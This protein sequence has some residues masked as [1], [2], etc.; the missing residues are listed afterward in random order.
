MEEHYDEQIEAMEEYYEQV[1]EQYEAQIDAL[2]AELDAFKEGY[3][4]AEDMDNAR[5][6]AEVMAANEEAETWRGRLEN[7]AAAVTEYNRLLAMLGE[8]GVSASADFNPSSLSHEDIVQVSQIDHKIKTRATGDSDFSG[9]EIALV[10]ESPNAELVLGSKLNRSVNSGE[11]VHLS[12]GSGV[13]NAESTSTLA[14]ILNGLAKPNSSGIGRS[15]QQNFS[16]GNIT[17]PNVTDAD[18][19]VKTLSTQFNNYAIQYGNRR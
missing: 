14:G 2:Q 4:K 18:S 1:Q 6:A 11:L 16:F 12:R 17:L 15:T 10:G 3:Q 9:D 13:V 5:L 19:F 7:L 8:A